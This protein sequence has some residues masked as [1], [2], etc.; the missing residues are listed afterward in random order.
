MTDKE[1]AV[2]ELKSKGLS[3]IYDHG[4]PMVLYDKGQD[5]DV[6]FQAASEMLKSLGYDA[7]FGVRCRT[8]RDTE[9][10]D[11][12]ETVNIDMENEEEI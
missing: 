1:K 12:V 9:T 8:G 11:T 10:V 6:V 3:V 2:K 5:A 7:S 4:I